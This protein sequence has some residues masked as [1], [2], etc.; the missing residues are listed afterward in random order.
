M[1]IDYTGKPLDRFSGMSES[2]RH[3]F[4][5]NPR[6]YRNRNFEKNDPKL[7]KQQNPYRKKDT[8]RPDYLKDYYLDGEV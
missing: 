4:L 8:R 5:H 6:L 7:S 3:K 2:Y 1:G